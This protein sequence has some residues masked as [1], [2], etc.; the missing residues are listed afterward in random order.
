MFEI[1]INNLIFKSNKSKIINKNIILF[2][3]S[4]DAIKK[5][6]KEK[7]N[8]GKVRINKIKVGFK[9]KFFNEFDIL[10]LLIFLNINIFFGNFKLIFL[11][12][13][14]CIKPN[15]ANTGAKNIM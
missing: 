2:F 12:N 4:D 11:K 8:I 10:L 9:V 7:G 5:L 13:R 3:I 1:K 6:P 14:T 15:V